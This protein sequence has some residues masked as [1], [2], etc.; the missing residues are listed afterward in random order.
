MPEGTSFKADQAKDF[1]LILS[2]QA[3]V[4]VQGRPRGKLGPGDHFG[5]MSV[6]DGGP[7]SA[8]VTA[9]GAVLAAGG[10]GVGL[11][12]AHWGTALLGAIAPRDLLSGY[13][14]GIDGRVLVF[15]L[16]TSML[17]AIAFS[18]V[19]A[20]HRSGGTLP[21]RLRGEGRGA[22]AGRERQRGRRTLVTAEL[23]LALVVIAGAGLLL[24]S[25]V[26]AQRVDPGFTSEGVLSF[27]TVLPGHRYRSTASALRMTRSRCAAP[28]RRH[29]RRDRSRRI[30]RSAR[31]VSSKTLVIII[32]SEP[33]SSA[34]C[35]SSMRSR[36]S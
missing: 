2:G 9:E 6:L 25:F 13:A 30:A 14:V 17:V 3:S 26:N 36:M 21:A 33:R 11:F 5:E 7:R 12:V 15:T 24:R 31:P 10:A 8:T 1:Y 29:Q 23:A 28:G 35:R 27:E 20:L 22:S 16:V 32:R 18:L 19:P 4:W 34:A